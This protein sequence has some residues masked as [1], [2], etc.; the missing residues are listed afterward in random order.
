MPG[1]AV[2]F[3]IPRQAGRDLSAMLEL[4]ATRPP[5]HPEELINTLKI[6][7]INDIHLKKFTLTT[8]Y[9]CFSLLVLLKVETSIVNVRHLNKHLSWL[10]IDIRILQVCSRAE[11][12]DMGRMYTSIQV[13]LP[14]WYTI[15][16][17]EKNTFRLDKYTWQ[18]EMGDTRCFQRYRY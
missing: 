9:K 2:G 18:T 17:G 16:W 11:V 3:S 13:R 12:D 1:R 15:L 8:A 6:D 4:F 5:Q 14:C 10:E 7:N